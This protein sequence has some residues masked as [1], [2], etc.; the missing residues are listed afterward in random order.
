MAS[1]LLWPHGANNGR[2]RD[3]NEASP[4]GM[5]ARTARAGLDSASTSAG[6]EGRWAPHRGFWGGHGEGSAGGGLS[7]ARR[8]RGWAQHIGASYNHGQQRHGRG[9]RLGAQSGCAYRR[10][11][12]RRRI[13]G[14]HLSRQRG[15]GRAGAR[16]ENGSHAEDA[17]RRASRDGLRARDAG[18]LG[19]CTGDGEA[20]LSA[21]ASSVRCCVGEKRRRLRE[22]RGEP[23][24]KSVRAV[25]R[26]GKRGR[27]RSSK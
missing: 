2:A 6:T 1:R 26:G 5:S 9:M 3:D 4:C 20:A 19:G 12:E 27:G 18:G 22:R 17:S 15:D 23:G 16:T 14:A 11:R 24:L 21:A 8:S 7:A 25:M 13:D 10:E